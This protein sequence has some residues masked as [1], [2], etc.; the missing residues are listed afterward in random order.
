MR[1]QMTPIMLVNLGTC[2]VQRVLDTINADGDPTFICE[3]SIPVYNAEPQECLGIICQTGWPDDIHNTG[4]ASFLL[5]TQV[6]NAYGP[7]FI[8]NEAEIY[9]ANQENGQVVWNHVARIVPPTFKPLLG[10]L[11]FAGKDYGIQLKGV[12]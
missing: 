9:E 12:A 4:L 2:D 1:T 6:G 7:F 10:T 3:V 11:T 8:D 5:D